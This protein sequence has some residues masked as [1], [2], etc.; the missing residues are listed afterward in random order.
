RIL[1]GFGGIESRNIS[2]Y[3]SGWGSTRNRKTAQSLNYG[4]ISVK[5]RDQCLKDDLDPSQFC[6]KGDGVDA[7]QGDSG[8][9]F[10]TKFRQRW[11][12]IGI[13]SSGV[14]R[15][16]TDVNMG[17]YTNLVRMMQWLRGKVTDLEYE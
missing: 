15:H 3:V 12:Q 2:G 9:P 6:A 13:V 16:C 14:N 10:A 1:T 8:G 17:Y 5:P 11:I 7:C 4:F